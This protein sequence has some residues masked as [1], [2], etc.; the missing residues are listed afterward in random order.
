M[1][2]A[3]PIGAKREVALTRVNVTVPVY[4]EETKIRGSIATLMCFLDR[5][6]FPDFEV[7]I[8]DN[9]STDDTWSIASELANRYSR[10]QVAHL[11]RRG[12]GRALKHVWLSSS[13][14]MLSYMDVDLSTDLAAW[15]RLVEPLAAGRYDLATGSRLL[16][17]SQTT[18][19][20]KREWISRAYNF[21]IKA[22]FDTGFSDAQCGFKAITRRAAHVLLPMVEDN[23]WFF[24]TELLVL[25]EKLGYGIF[26]LPV[27]WVENPDSRVKIC[28]TAIEDLRGLVRLRRR[29]MA[30][31]ALARPRQSCGQHS[32]AP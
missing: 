25:A 11:E 24:D 28:R 18:R 3:E 7:V 22:L 19:S 8:A 1:D 5:G 12:R 29:L 27:C 4:N 13:A 30:H 20:F 10:V 15:P 23:N 9:G 6:C 14:N 17:A 21:L 31:G 32:Q 16:S 2:R 26:D